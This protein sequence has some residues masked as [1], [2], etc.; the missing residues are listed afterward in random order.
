MPHQWFFP[1][2]INSI[3]SIIPNSIDQDSLNTAA[4]ETSID[5]MP[6]EMFK[7]S[8]RQV[9]KVRQSRN[10]AAFEAKMS[11]N[12]LP[13]QQSPLMLLNFKDIVGQCFSTERTK[14]QLPAPP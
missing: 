5:N 14:P 4:E 12:L 2:C 1:D 8:S 7:K 6:R 9:I 11:T 13:P 3:H 10:K